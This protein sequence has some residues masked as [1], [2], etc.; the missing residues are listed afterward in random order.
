MKIFL[1]GASGFIG[2]EL[3]KRLR[4]RH[5][6]IAMARDE[7][8]AEKIRQLHI[9]PVLCNLSNVEPHHLQNADIVVHSAAYA[10]E[11]GDDETYYN[12]NVLG[13]ERMLRA[14]QSAGVARFIFLSSDAVIFSGEDLLDVDETYPRA[15][16]SPYPYSRTKA[17]AENAV[18]SA[19][20]PTFVTIALRPRLVWGPH[21]TTILPVIV[22][23]I[24]DKK[25]MWIDG[26]KYLTSMT[27]VDNLIAAIELA[28]TR[29]KGGEAYFIA[30]DERSNI[31]DFVTSYVQSQHITPPSRSL[32][33]FLVRGLARLVAVS[34][35]I[36]HIKTKPPITPFAIDL[37]SANVTLNTDKAKKELGY[38]PVIHLD[39]GM[40]QL[41]GQ[42]TAKEK[43]AML[44]E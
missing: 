44:V 25:F 28:L 37:M 23:M 18:L 15:I 19:N 41:Y 27:H 35:K 9:T 30:D 4:T 33:K 12:T 2:G 13:T 31:K 7:R 21:D 20:S 14:A 42:E 29:G 16:D 24:K 34:W 38:H 26:G 17:Q 10:R 36:F 32:P 40:A 5:E 6:I 43:E 39:E 8:A 1:T 22:Q 3:A 11:W